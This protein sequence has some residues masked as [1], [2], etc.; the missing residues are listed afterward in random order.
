MICV[1]TGSK[2]MLKYRKANNGSRFTAAILQGD[3]AQCRGATD[4]EAK[5]ALNKYMRLSEIALISKPDIVIWP[6]T[7]V[8]LPYRSSHAM[9]LDYRFRLNTLIQKHKIPFLIGTIDFEDIPPGV[10]KKAEI[11]NSALLIDKNGKIADKFHKINLV[12]FGEFVPLSGM[13]PF[14]VDAIGMGR[15]LTPGTDFSPI[16]I[17]PGVRAGIGI[18]FEDIFPYVARNE[19]KKGANLLIYITNDAWYPTSSEPEQHLANSVFRAVENRRPMIRCGNNSG[20]CLILPNG[21]IADS[22]FV[23]E[24]LDKNGKKKLLLAKR[25]EG[26]ANFIVDVRPNPPMTFYTRHG[27]MFILLC[28]AIF[29]YASI[30][31]LWSWRKKKTALLEKFN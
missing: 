31:A 16:E 19:V 20:S 13:F 18:C 9:C 30:I 6:E 29:A 7:A 5:A 24:S 27:D 8:P 21:V 11:Y 28:W 2:S 14:L 12:P 1:L 4:K 3:I 23:D 26:C 10:N 25:G 17:I 22:I 15:Q